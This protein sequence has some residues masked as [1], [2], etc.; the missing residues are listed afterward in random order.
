MIR[1]IIAGGAVVG[2]LTL[3]MTG[4]AGATTSTTGG[5]NTSTTTATHPAKAKGCARL[6]KIESHLKSRAGKVNTRISKAQASAAKLKNEGHTKAAD[7]IEAKIKK[8][9]THQAKV[10]ARLSRLQSKCNASGGSS[11][12]TTPTTTS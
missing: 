5:T 4:M 2:A 10:K 7:K 6:P 9:E 12:S 8:V 1:R 11:T 3:G